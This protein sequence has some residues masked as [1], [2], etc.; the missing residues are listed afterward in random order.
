MEKKQNAILSRIY[1]NQAVA[2]VEKHSLKHQPEAEAK[3]ADKLR[4]SAGCFSAFLF[5]K[6]SVLTPHDG[7]RLL[8]FFRG[9]LG[10]FCFPFFY[11]RIIFMPVLSE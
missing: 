7:G 11:M 9:F 4:D 6:P 1:V 8:Y 2:Y 3:L 5:S 10:S